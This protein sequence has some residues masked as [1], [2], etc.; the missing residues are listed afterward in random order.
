MQ[1]SPEISDRLRKQLN[2]SVEEQKSD[3]SPDRLYG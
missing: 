2:A 1:I 3:S